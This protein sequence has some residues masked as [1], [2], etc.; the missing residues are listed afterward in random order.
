MSDMI[1]TQDQIDAIFNEIS[2]GDRM[3]VHY[4]KVAGKLARIGRSSKNPGLPALERELKNHIRSLAEAKPYS[5]DF[6]H[7]FKAGF[8]QFSEEALGVT[9]D[10]PL[11]ELLVTL[12]SLIGLMFFQIDRERRRHPRFP[13]A[14]AMTLALAEETRVFGIDISSGGISFYAPLSLPP[15]RRFEVMVGSMRLAVDI[16]QVTGMA[17]EQMG[18]FRTVCTFPSPLPWESIRDLIRASLETAS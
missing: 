3:Q 14:A 11:F 8:R 2:I 5:P 18:C 10:Y 1:I 16:L 9:K 15:G 7:A 12:E 4:A 17:P 6:I 13:L